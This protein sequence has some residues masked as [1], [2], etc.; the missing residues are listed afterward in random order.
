MKTEDKIKVAYIADKW[1]HRFIYGS[2]A[3]NAI[4]F[5]VLGLPAMTFLNILGCVIVVAVIVAPCGF[6]VGA[7]MM[8]EI[9]RNGFDDVR[10]TI[11]TTQEYL[12]QEID[13]ESDEECDVDVTYIG[14]P[15]GQVGDT[16]M[17]DAIE[18]DVRG[19]KTKFDFY[20]VAQKVGGEYV[21]P[22]VSGLMFIRDEGVLYAAKE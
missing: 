15:T 14:E 19:V 17:Y 6:V 11:K 22:T 3:A 8:A 16:L 18:C 9:K 7:G 21:S 20:G 10:A 13:S 12:Q 4:A 1:W 5:A 2:V